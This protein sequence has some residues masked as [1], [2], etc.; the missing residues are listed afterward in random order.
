MY[1]DSK[2]MC[3]AIVLLVKPFVWCRSRRRRRRRLL[4]LTSMGK[5]T[6]ISA[7]D[8]HVITLLVLLDLCETNMVPKGYF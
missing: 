7:C 3:A 6:E 1:Q 5:R 2:C 8:C 4:K